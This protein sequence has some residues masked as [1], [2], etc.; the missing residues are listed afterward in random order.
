MSLLARTRVAVTTEES[1]PGVPNWGP[2]QVITELKDGET[3]VAF[4]NLIAGRRY[5]VRTWTEDAFGNKSPERLTVIDT[6]PDSTNPDRPTDLTLTAGTNGFT[7]TWSPVE[8]ADLAE[9][10]IA[11]ADDD[12]SGS[13]PGTNAFTTRKT[14][15]TQMWIDQ[16]PTQKTWVQ[17]RARDYSGNVSPYTTIASITP[18]RVTPISFSANGYLDSGSPMR[19]YVKVP[20]LQS[21]TEAAIT[22][23]FRQFMAPSTAAS[24]GGADTSGSSSAGSSSS[25]LTGLTFVDTPAAVGSGTT[26][27][28][29]AGTAHTHGGGSLET[30]SGVLVSVS[31][32][33]SH[34]HS[35]PHTH[36]TPN[37]TH[38]LTYGTYE[39]TYPV[40]HSVKVKTYKRVAGTWTLQDTSASLTGDLEDLD[41]TSV[42]TSAGD[43]RFEVLSDAAQPNGGRLGLDLFGLITIVT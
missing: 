16:T 39:E 1:S 14:R 43:W 5:Y 17:V 21:V 40:S 31:G 22:L 32:T 29:S 42:I 19:A 37:H 11:F 30:T 4:E 25:D 10:E 34:N 15:T 9:Y 24:S 27:A 38:S 8:D 23:A 36:S 26:G 12:G 41:L 6:P 20:A 13:G 33:G 18:V 7:A 35:I 3:Q 2:N 28:A